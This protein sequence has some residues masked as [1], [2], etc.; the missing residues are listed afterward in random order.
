M[1]QPS[2]V[3]YSL[4]SVQRGPLVAKYTGALPGK[5]WGE[6]LSEPPKDQGKGACTS[7]WVVA[8]PA[9][10]CEAV[11]SP[12][13]PPQ[14]RESSP[15]LQGLLQAVRRFQLPLES[16]SRTVDSFP[17]LSRLSNPHRLS[18][19]TLSFD[20]LTVMRAYSSAWRFGNILGSLLSPEY[21]LSI[22][23]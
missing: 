19:D 3:D 17:S 8:V 18:G 2:A 16:R 1:R 21:F 6:V 20:K 14:L 23:K 11:Q 4:C 9:W 15:Q 7:L 5:S 12:R 10:P 22:W 13:S